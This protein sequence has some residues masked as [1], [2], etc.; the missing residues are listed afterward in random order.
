[1]LAELETAALEGRL[2][3]LLEWKDEYL[4]GLEALDLEHRDL[5]QCINDL[6]EQCRIQPE[7]VEVE[8]C[9][10]QLYARLAAHFA[11]E[12]STMLEMK[13]PHYAAHKSEHD[14]FLEEVT[15]VVASFSTAP[16]EEHIEAFALRL[17]DWIV[18]HITGPDR[19]LVEGQR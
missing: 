5:F 2:M 7:G 19:Q 1:V 3:A 17:R 9:L 10:G 11:L 13:N 12:E 8:A 6:Y 4:L 16:G 15:G 14:Q 18:A